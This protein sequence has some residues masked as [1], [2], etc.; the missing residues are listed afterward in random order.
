[1]IKEYFDNMNLESEVQFHHIT[2][3]IFKSGLGGSQNF[4]TLETKA[5]N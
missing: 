4:F 1:M 2:R 3:Y 5:I